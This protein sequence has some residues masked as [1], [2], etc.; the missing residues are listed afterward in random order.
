MIHV[1]HTYIYRRHVR[2][3]L[4]VCAHNVSWARCT[5][6]GNVA[7]DVMLAI[8]SEL[9]IQELAMRIFFISAYAF[10][11][12]RNGKHII[13]IEDLQTVCGYPHMRKNPFAV[14]A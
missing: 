4:E 7:A 3:T 14:Y 8:V 6:A 10:R 2:S 11:F 13:R 9:F 12:M 1:I 5:C